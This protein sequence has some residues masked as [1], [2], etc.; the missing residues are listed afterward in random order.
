MLKSRYFFKTESLC[1]KNP[2]PKALEVY[3]VLAGVPFDKKTVSLI[4]K[5]QDHIKFIL[6]NKL[7]YFVKPLNLGLEF[8][9]LKWPNQN[10]C[11]ILLKQAKEIL[12]SNS[13]GSFNVKIRGV[14]FNP[15]GSMLLR[16]Y[17]DNN[18]L[19]MFRELLK[20]RLTNIPQKQ[21]EWCHIPL[22]RILDPVS[23]E[24]FKKLREIYYSEDDF[25]S[26]EVPVKEFHIVH[27]KQ[28]YMEDK[29][30]IETFELVQ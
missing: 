17:P 28:W 23:T 8:I 15:D 3:A 21:S 27:E 5:I 16:G 12:A 10:F 11:P 18:S 22:G 4:S 9:V 6:G 25:C 1:N 29:N 20:Q 2:V 14:Q 26:F 30:I 13:F 7:S 24:I 19:K